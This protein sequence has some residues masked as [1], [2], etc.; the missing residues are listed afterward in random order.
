MI[1]L[2]AADIERRPLVLVVDDDFTIRMLVT[3]ALSGAGF[4]VLE[5][6]DGQQGLDMFAARQPEIVLLDVMMPGMDGFT[7]CTE[8][9]KLPDGNHVPVLMMT[10]LDDMDSVNHAYAA[11]ATDFITK[12]INYALLGHRVRYMLRA[13]Q[14]MER[15]ADS[16][17]SLANAQRIANLGNW[18]WDTRS[19]TISCSSQTLRILDLPNNPQVALFSAFPWVHD[20]DRDRIKAWFRHALSTGDAP[21]IICRIQRSDGAELHVRMQGEA[22]LNGTGQI[23]RIHGTLQDITE[24]R[25]AEE[26]IHELAYYDSLTGLPN[27]GFFMTQVKLALDHA[28]RHQHLAALLF[29]DLDNFKRV[30]DTLGHGMGDKLLKLVAERISDSLYSTDAVSQISY[31][32]DN[33]NIARL[34]GDEFTVLLSRIGQAEDAT[35]V[36][37]RI[38]DVVSQ[39][40]TL[41]NQEVFV[42]P[43]IGVA[44]FPRDGTLTETLLKHADMAMYHAK[45]AGKGTFRF[46]DETMHESASHR[47]IMELHLRK[48][49]ELGE[50]YLHYQPQM[51]AEKNR[52]CGIE[53][54]L[55]WNNTE[56]GP[57]SPANFIPLAE[58]TGLI[59]PIGEWVLRSACQQ[60]QAWID[61]GI[62]FDRMA[63]NISVRQ[64]SSAGFS[65][66]IARILDETGLEPAMLEL[67]VTESL[68]MSD[69]AGAIAILRELKDT[70]IHVAIDDFGTGYSN[71]AYLKQFPIDRIKID[72]MF[73]RDIVADPNDAAIATAVIEMAHGMDIGVTAEGVET[74]AQL[75]ILNKLHCD[76]MQG[77]YFGHPMS[78]DEIVAYVGNHE[79]HRHRIDKR[80]SLYP[81]VLLVD[82]D[83]QTLAVLA[84]IV[85]QAGY[86]AFT[87]SSAVDGLEILAKQRVSVV[88][89]DYLMPGMDGVEFF[90]R[91]SKIHPH[92]IRMMLSG[93][94][95]RQIV[96]DA[97]NDGAIS[98]FLEK[99]V[100]PG[101]LRNAL[102]E[103]LGGRT[104]AAGGNPFAD[105]S[106]RRT[107]TG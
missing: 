99:P 78:A 57:V 64:F 61:A 49:L 32:R 47:L 76:E 66:L 95:N 81:A 44:V 70:G 55:R 51:D 40:F 84:R 105:Q 54:L 1:D 22:E 50:L 37:E 24:L 14:A 89:S 98:R 63:V 30:N 83:D 23:H 42:T 8:L 58:E 101:I 6:E 31:D 45:R 41:D 104:R 38:L 90:R 15:L 69:A 5:A 3:E 25:Q 13:Y 85:R 87:A 34:G 107:D 20:S 11:G 33:S 68:L 92:T 56:L 26:R 75:E 103:V 96:I 18:E 88:I 2:V 80:I 52:I 28:S 39:S 71:L 79:Q 86:L 53:A 93:H 72:R 7:M 102:R 16:E 17:R 27:R 46:F 35:I 4:E 77:F 100:K 12:P 73:V 48:A 29:V 65:A 82:D 9:R 97:I 60:A 91:V 67:E 94:S 36:A 74:E 21:N 59:I 43:S 19:S 10:G 62:D 106:S